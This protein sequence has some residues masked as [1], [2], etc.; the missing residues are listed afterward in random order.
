MRTMSADLGEVEE[1]GMQNNH[2]PS[3]KEA[4]GTYINSLSQSDRNQTQQELLKFVRWCGYD[5]SF[6]TLNPPEIGR[7]AETLG[8]YGTTPG[9]SKRLEIVRG[10][11][12]FAN[13]QGL[14]QQNLSQHARFRNANVK[15]RNVTQAQ[16]AEEVFL[17]PE[18]HE[19]LKKELNNLKNEL[20]HI[21][22]DIRKAAADKDVRENAPLEAA[23]EHQGHIQSRIRDIERK[24]QAAVVVSA[25]AT[26]NSKVVR[27]GCTIELQEVGSGRKMVFRL[28]NP[29]EA[30][31]LD[32]RVSSA[33]PVGK[34][35]LNQHEGREFQVATPGGVQR[36]L[37]VWVSA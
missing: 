27:I 8:A 16:A 7:Y 26:S 28:V 12:A 33:S 37:V 11:L 17:T 30:N 20:V 5:R 34:A 19:E 13:K 1:A 3:M 10:F 9:S 25:D 14:T 4:V 29:S 23:R 6:S 36:Y 18:G 24:L 35:L 21:A 22:E 31:P 2:G 32:G 15:R